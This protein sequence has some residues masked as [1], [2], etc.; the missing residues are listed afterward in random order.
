MRKKPS[1][2]KSTSIFFTNLVEYEVC[3]LFLSAPLFRRARAPPV[4]DSPA[5]GVEG[6]DVH[7]GGEGAEDEVEAGQEGAQYRLVQATEGPIVEYVE[8]PE[9]GKRGYLSLYI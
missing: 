5:G 7:E 8:V 4:V 6:E 9:V 1:F 3:A 2:L